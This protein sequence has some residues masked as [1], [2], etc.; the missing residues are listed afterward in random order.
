MNKLKL[1]YDV[2]MTMKDKELFNGNIKVEGSKGKIQVFNFNNQF[3]KNMAEG[4]IKANIS[5]E[6]DC[7]GKKVKHESSTEFNTTGAFHHGHCHHPHHG[8]LKCCGIKGHLSKLAFL[9]SMLHSM[10][11]EEQEDKSALMTLSFDDIP[12]DMKALLQEKMSRHQMNHGHCCHGVLKE[13]S[14][15]EM[16]NTRLTIRV[17]KNNEVEKVLLNVEGKAKDEPGA[18]DPL[19]LKAELNLVW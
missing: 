9:V 5:L 8:G 4:R 10:K 1:L 11:V 2:I 13:F 12:A 16:V 7:A 15:M 17:N 19:N 6:T 3:E 14:G 18:T